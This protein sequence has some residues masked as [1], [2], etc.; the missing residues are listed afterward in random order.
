[1][2]TKW[3]ILRQRQIDA[4][5][6]LERIE[7]EMFGLEQTPCK[8]NCAGCNIYLETEAD[9]ADHFEIPDEQYLN[10]GR[11]PH[12]WLKEVNVWGTD[13]RLVGE[14]FCAECEHANSGHY[15]NCPHN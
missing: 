1:M 7:N 12:N 15:T 10:L 14:D 4:R 8:L 9:F 5:A 11:C 2:K 13:K 3:E 6:D